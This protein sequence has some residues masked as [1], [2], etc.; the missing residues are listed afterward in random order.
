MKC[1]N[2]CGNEAKFYSKGTKRW[3]CEQFPSQ[4]PAQKKK[5]QKPRTKESLEKAKKTCIEKYGVENPAQL[6]DVKE[7]MKE[8]CLERYGVEYALSSHGIREKIK[9]SIL[10]EYGVQ[11]ISQAEAIKKRKIETCLENYGVSN[12]SQSEDIKEKKRQTNLK[13]YNVEN[14]MNV[15]EFS[16]KMA[17]NTDY[18]IQT[19]NFQ[20]TMIER[21]GVSNPSQVSEFRDKALKNSYKKK[22]Y[23][24][25]SGKIEYCQGYEPQM[26]DWLLSQ[27]Y[28]ENDI[29]VSDI[30]KPEIWYEFDGKKR[31]YYPDIFIKSEN[32]IIEVKSK[33]TFTLDKEKNN[34]KLSA[35]R[36]LNFSSRIYVFDSL[37]MSFDTYDSF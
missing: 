6:E 35:C 4:C 8:T 3:R 11:H 36:K 20:N 37:R 13:R 30:E 34:I 22:E 33:Y 21:Y 23:V 25:P 19:Q 24:F 1:D 9:Q 10:E 5:R 29:I 17:E 31:R 2:G 26:I 32:M 14:P 28:E 16:K 7:K 27:G 12:P 15:K 18:I